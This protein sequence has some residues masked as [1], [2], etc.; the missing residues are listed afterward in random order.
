[1][2]STR[3]E[4]SPALETTGEML[5]MPVAARRSGRRAM[6]SIVAV[7]AAVTAIALGSLLVAGGDTQ[8]AGTA[9]SGVPSTFDVVG[10]MSL[11]DTPYYAT[12]STGG[13]CSGDGGYSDLRA[14]AMINIR[15]DGNLVAQGNLG[16]GKATGRTECVF[17]IS[18]DDVPYRPG[19]YTWEVSHRGELILDVEPG[20]P[21]LAFG[22]IGD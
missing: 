13:T 2:S 5:A 9:T 4:Q 15:R 20:Q 17:G 7:G 12:W 3:T 8:V 14:G 22:S 10:S 1:M 11:T 16:V 6:T 18:V 21:A 19:T